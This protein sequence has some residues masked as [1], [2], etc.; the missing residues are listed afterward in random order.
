MSRVLKLLLTVA[1]YLCVGLGVVGAF[2]P[3]LPTVPFIL[4]A[5]WLFVKSS[6]KSMEWLMRH[7]IFAKIVLNFQTNRGIPLHVKII[8]LSTMWVSMTLCAILFVEALWIR[9]ML[10][11][12][13]VGVTIHILRYK[14]LKEK[15]DNH[16]TR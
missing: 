15:N 8:V 14:T 2:V 3:I 12:V 7:R 16:K 11:A 6:P 10:A 1:G 4:L 9:L 13:A 5:A